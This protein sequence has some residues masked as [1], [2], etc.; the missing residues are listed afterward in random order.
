M[1][2]L[3]VLL[4][5]PQ[6]WLLA[7]PSGVGMVLGAPLPGLTLVLSDRRSGLVIA[8][9]LQPSQLVVAGFGG[10]GRSYPG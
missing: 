4:S 7:S 10:G 1:D 6:L 2:F 8:R 3:S 5:S 9:P